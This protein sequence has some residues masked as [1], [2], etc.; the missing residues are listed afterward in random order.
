MKNLLLVMIDC[1]RTEKTL[2]GL[3]GGSPG[4][5]WPSSLAA[6]QGSDDGRKRSNRNARR[7]ILGMTRE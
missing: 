4:A 1:A 5:K 3:A 6:K 2:G 7:L